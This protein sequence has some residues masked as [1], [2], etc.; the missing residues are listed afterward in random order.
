MEK[1]V[2]SASVWL[3]MFWTASRYLLLVNSLWSI[4]MH[5]I[6]GKRRAIFIIVPISISHSVFPSPFPIL[7]SCLH[8][9][10]CLPISISHSVFP[11]PFP[12]LSSCLHFPFCFSV[13]ISGSFYPSPFPILL[14]HLHFLFCLPVSVSGYF[15]PSHLTIRSFFTL[16]K[17]DPSPS[18]LPP[19][20]QGPP[21]DP[22]HTAGCLHNK[23]QHSTDHST[24][25]RKPAHSPGGGDGVQHLLCL[26][27]AGEGE[28]GFDLG[29]VGDEGEAVFLASGCQLLYQLLDVVQHQPKVVWAHARARVQNEHDVLALLAVW[30]TCPRASSRHRLLLPYSVILCSTCT[31]CC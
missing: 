26:V 25:T 13:S 17:H 22:K 12:I 3:T 2:A 20:S 28:D 21:S 8:F 27:V 11:S 5:I 9:P 16:V 19:H 6:V 18:N 31:E 15:S 10:F 1:N 30:Q 29:A 4:G 24:D 7:S 23:H 14:S